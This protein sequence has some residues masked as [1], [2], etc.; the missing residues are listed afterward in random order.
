MNHS[1]PLLRR[2]WL[3][4]APA[5]LASL[6]AQAQR[7]DRHDEGF[8]QILRATYG[9]EWRN[10]DVTERVRQLAMQDGQFRASNDTF[11]IDPAPRETK[12]LWIEVQGRDGER[13]TFSYREGNLV[14]G[15]QFR[16]YGGAYPGHS[17]PGHGGYPDRQDWRLI[18]QATFGTE[19]RTMDVTQRVRQLMAQGASFRVDPQ[20]MGGDP[21][22]GHTKFLEI[23]LRGH[24]RRVL[25]FK[26]DSWV[27]PQDIL[28]EYPR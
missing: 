12:T 8:F 9:T 16:G 19:R 26:E 5:L 25:R 1:Q 23:R 3:L 15:A 17:R 4:L 18:E 24:G 22:Y 11:G 21:A 13:R 27:D 6:T 10:V 14:D 28:D 20:T 7:Y 2:Q